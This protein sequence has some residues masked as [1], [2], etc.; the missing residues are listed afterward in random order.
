M[1]VSEVE[2]WFGFNTSKYYLNKHDA[3]G[4]GPRIIN[5]PIIIVIIIIS[6]FHEDN[7]LSMGLSWFKQYLLV[8]IN[9]IVNIYTM[10]C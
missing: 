1:S 3:I 7:T 8:I 6:L 10:S 2:C 5:L 9:T 4:S